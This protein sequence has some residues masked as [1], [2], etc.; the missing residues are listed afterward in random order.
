MSEMMNSLLPLG[1]GGKQDAICALMATNRES[2]KNGLILSATEA[3]EIVRTRDRALRNFGRVEIG[4]QSVIKLI[5]AFCGSPYI[6]RQEYPEMIKELV[7]AFYQ[8]KNET[9]DRLGDDELLAWMH[10]CFDQRCHGSLELLLGR[11][12]DRLVTEVRGSSG[13]CRRCD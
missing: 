13:Y 10:R 12:L 2:Q 7:E 11:E 6:N 8:I 1:T 5:A 9:Q 4:M 3:E